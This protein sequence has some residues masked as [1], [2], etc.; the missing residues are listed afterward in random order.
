MKRGQH[1]DKV[2][3]PVA[4]WGTIRLLMVLVALNNWST[5][6]IDYVQAFPQAPVEKDLYLKVP[7][8]FDIEGGNKDDYALKLHRNVYG[9]KQAG[10]VW[11][12]F[13]TKKLIK[14]VGFKQSKIDECL[15]YRGQTLYLLYTD[16]S[17]LAGP[18]A[19]EIEQIIEEIKAT[20]LE[21]ADEGKMEDFLGV[22]IQ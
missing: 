6:Q 4:S 1:F 9:Q 22:N 17:I 19:E 15:F 12:K 7:T 20:G 10:K 21:I 18:D 3:D 8:G 14:Q 11:Y 16:D 13:L 5:K 2:Y